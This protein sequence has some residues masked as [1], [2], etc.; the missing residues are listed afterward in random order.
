M[1]VD[2]QAVA[3]QFTTFYYQQFDADRAQL[4]NLYRDSSMLTFETSQVQGA[5]SIV[6]KLVS[7]PFQ[8]VGHRITTLDAQPASPTGGDIIVMVTGELLVDEEQNAQRYSQV[9]HLVPE[10]NSFFVFNDIFRLNYS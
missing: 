7:L 9:F 8:K 3:Q 2:F 4:G 10:D 6:E 1:S 5:K